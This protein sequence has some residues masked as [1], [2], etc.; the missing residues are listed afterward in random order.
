VQ[1]QYPEKSDLEARTLRRVV[2]PIFLTVSIQSL[3]CMTAVTVPVFMP[4]LTADMNISSSYT[5]I[6]VTLIYVGATISAPFSGYI[7]DRFGPVFV[8]QICLVLCALGLAAVSTASI[9]WFMVGAFIMGLGYGP[10][11]PASSHLLARNSP[12]GI[13]SVVFSIK[14]TGVPLGGAMAGAIVPHLVIFC[15]W[16]RTALLVGAF[17]IILSL[18][19]LPWRKKFDGY[20][21]T[22]SPF[23]WKYAVAPIKIT[24]LNRELRQIVVTSFFFIT[25]QLCL[26]SFLV[27][28]LTQDVGMTLI[29]AGLM[30]SVAQTAGVIGRVAWGGLVDRYRNPYSML[31]MMG[32]A[33]A[34]GA[35]CLAM[36]SP[37]WPF[38]AVLIICVLF[39]AV[40]IGWNGVYL[41]E[42]ARLVKPENAGMATGGSLFFT[43]CGVLLGLPAF[44][45]I[46]DAT[47][48]YPIGFVS[49]AAGTLICGLL[50][51]FSRRS[52]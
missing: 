4:V 15:G 5:G 29:Q 10:V 13:M 40:A 32:L 6:F 22:F 42:V 47:G 3:V 37:G 25:M 7:I 23:Y 46:V 1:I 41:S 48:S 2:W 45:I 51:I 9:L 20:S 11:T 16:R 52:R 49:A 18:L 36:F 43:Y 27:I 38:A 19:I 31:G 8:S 44:S 17:N 33:M 12:P 35:I 39:G 50:L 34:F 24:F 30:L 28:Y 14:Q 21:R 26:V